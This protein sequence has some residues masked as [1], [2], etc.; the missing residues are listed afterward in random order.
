MRA[1]GGCRASGGRAARGRRERRRQRCGCRRPQTAPAA[2]PTVAAARAAA[3][4]AAAARAAAGLVL[5]VTVEAAREAAGW[6]AA[7]AAARRRRRGPWRRQRRRAKRRARRW[8]R[9][10]R[11]RRRRRGQ[12]GGLGGWRLR[13]RRRQR[14][15]ASCAQSQRLARVEQQ[16]DSKR[17]PDSRSVCRARARRLA[18]GGAQRRCGTEFR[19]AAPRHT[20]QRRCVQ[21][22]CQPQVEVRARKPWQ[23]RGRGRSVIGGLSAGLF[24]ISE[25]VADRKCVAEARGAPSGAAH[26]HLLQGVAERVVR[27]GCSDRAANTPGPITYRVSGIT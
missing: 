20:Q 5:A 19:R 1:R 17:R 8:W 14:L 7:A 18:F 9:L 24:A 22:S 12:R 6:V 10:G 3:A 21:A 4:R 15:D 25:P 27:P 2:V 26:A 13:W 23:R 11:S 16:E